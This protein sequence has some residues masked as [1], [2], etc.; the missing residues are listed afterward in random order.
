MRAEGGRIILMDFG[1][2]VEAKPG[3][4]ERWRAGLREL[5]STW[6]SST[7]GRLTSAA[8]IYS[9]G[10]LLY[11]AVSGAYPID[12]ERLDEL[13]KKHLSGAAVPSRPGARS[14]INSCR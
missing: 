6:P 4:R 3:L 2:G 13:I 11:F 9:L 5:C 1:A 14:P 8:D 12:A 10:V 7:S